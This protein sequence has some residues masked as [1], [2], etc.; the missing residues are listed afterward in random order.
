MTNLGHKKDQ[1]VVAKLKEGGNK[2]VGF[3]WEIHVRLPSWEGSKREG[4][5]V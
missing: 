5:S 2:W 3:R 1:L 4:R